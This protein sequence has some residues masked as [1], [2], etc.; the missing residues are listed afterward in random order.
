MKALFILVACAVISCANPGDLS[1]KRPL[2]LLR[3]TEKVL[4]TSGQFRQILPYDCNG[5]GREDLVLSGD[6]EI[7]CYLQNDVALE[8]SPFFALQ[9][10]EA[11]SCFDVA[12]NAGDKYPHV[13]VLTAGKI[14]VYQVADRHKHQVGEPLR[15]SDCFFDCSRRWPL[16]YDL[17]GNGRLDILVPVYN[18]TQRRWGF[19]AYIR[20]KDWRQVDVT[21]Q[22]GGTFERI[23]AKIYALGTWQGAQVLAEDGKE[24]HGYRFPADG[25]VKS[26]LFWTASWSKIVEEQSEHRLSP[27]EMQGMSIMGVRQLNRENEPDLIFGSSLDQRVWVWID[28]RYLYSL[29]V[30]GQFQFGVVFADVNQDGWDD[31][32]CISLQQ[33]SF[34]RSFFSYAFTSW[35]PLPCN[36]YVFFNQQGQFSSSPAQTYHRQLWVFPAQKRS[37][38]ACMIED[39][40]QDELLDGILLDNEGNLEYY[41][42][43]LHD[44]PA[45]RAV[46]ILDALLQPVYHYIWQRHWPPWRP[47][48]VM[49]LPSPAEYY[50]V[51]MTKLAR[52]NEPAL[53][54]LHYQSFPAQHDKIVVLVPLA[55]KDLQ[56]NP[57][58]LS[59]ETIQLAN[60]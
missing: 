19:R 56:I 7:V 21:G 34:W 33:P 57:K 31:I 55:N 9:F 39:C 25:L 47:D 8:A 2:F 41:A 54:V 17:D 37:M 46:G 24:L 4:E 14:L 42:N 13:V 29:Q 52:R 49:K 15:D 59:E 23:P 32:I 3:Y 27:I 1:Y 6:K 38:A 40:D 12:K 20:G 35:V 58:F 36:F 5:D 30:P 48:M 28:R 53:V 44:A 50:R 45:R 60:D 18:T 26:A 22:G 51:Y 10:P 43:I 16:W 11:I